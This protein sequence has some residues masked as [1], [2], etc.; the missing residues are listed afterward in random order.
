MSS[1][2]S[3]ILTL[4]LALCCCSCDS[5]DYSPKN[6]KLQSKTT[7]TNLITNQ[8]IQELTAE[9]LNS[10]KG[11]SVMTIATVGSAWLMATS[12]AT[13]V[14][15]Y[16]LQVLVFDNKMWVIGGYISPNNVDDVY[17]STDGTTWTLATSH[18]GFEMTGIFGAVVFSSKMWVMGGNNQAVWYSSDGA[19]WNLAGMAAWSSRTGSAVL[20]FNNKMWVMGGYSQSIGKSDVWSSV[21]GM[22][23]T[24]VNAAA[25]WQG[26]YAPGA[27]VYNNKM[28]IMGG[29]TPGSW[30]Y[31][32]DVWSSP[33][34]VTW[35]STTGTPSWTARVTPTV[36]VFDDKMWVYG[37]R[38]G[39]AVENGVHYTV[40]GIQW[41]TSTSSAD[42]IQRG[43]QSGAMFDNRMWIM[44]GYSYTSGELGDVWYS[45]PLPTDAPTTTPS[46]P[47]S[48][49]PTTSP[50]MAPS[51]LP[52][53]QPSSIPSA[54]P[55]SG[56]EMYRYALLGSSNAN[57][58]Y[59]QHSIEY[60]GFKWHPVAFASATWKIL[61][62][63]PVG[64]VL[65]SGLRIYGSAVAS[66][67][68][69]GV[70]YSDWQVHHDIFSLG[71]NSNAVFYC[72]LVDRTFSARV[73]GLVLLNTAS[74]GHEVFS[75]GS[76]G[77]TWTHLRSIAKEDK[78]T[79]MFEFMKA[80]RL[81]IW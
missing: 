73:I 69:G 4:A 20:A 52:T 18:A 24:L 2:A 76:S 12:A 41:F 11:S 38:G 48:L 23:W 32:Q 16:N 19:T 8:V 34:G 56:N 7:G 71:N 51:L 74:E 26:R 54:N 6:E 5:L 39:A 50:T 81:V 40:D 10:H 55:S 17:W 37:G 1:R 67:S 25:P 61:G 62:D 36:V 63:N 13:W 31:L 59:V 75:V 46:V 15:R 3:T 77:S 9:D 58:I 22:T 14:G 28:W 47:P 29:Q 64:G 68:E 45:E 80:S 79:G 43:F 21:D 53:T 70:L 33:D 65:E 49:F 44:G 60:D 27:V 42:W 35:T 72:W 30:N 66:A 78:N 57:I